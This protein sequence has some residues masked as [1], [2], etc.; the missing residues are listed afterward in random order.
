[1]PD[2]QFDELVVALSENQENLAARLLYR[3]YAPG[4]RFYLR[5]AQPGAPVDDA[6]LSVL[7]Q[8]ARQLRTANSVTV[9]EV[10]R[11]V[12]ELARKEA[13]SL[14]SAC[15]ISPAQPAFGMRE[16]DNIMN[17]LFT[18]LL[19]AEREVLLRTYLLDE[20][21]REIAA[22]TGLPQASLAQTRAE[23]RERFQILCSTVAN[24]A[25]STIN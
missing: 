3:R 17:S 20:S 12:L 8:A 7:I 25:P 19:P 24:R 2:G 6:V 16:Q 18:R 14:K 9:S 13:D 4:V 1:M 21:D 5:K 23:A 22:A 10:T 11:V 15:W